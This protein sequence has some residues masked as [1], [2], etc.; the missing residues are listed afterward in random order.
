MT[1][2]GKEKESGVAELEDV[3]VD[4]FIRLCQF[5]YTG[6]FTVPKP[7]VDVTEQ[8]EEADKKLA[9]ALSKVVESDDEYLGF[10]P[11][12]SKTIKKGRK[13][14][15]VTGWGLEDETLEEQQQR[16]QQGAAQ[17]QQQKFSE[18]IF[19]TEFP[20][21]TLARSCE[22]QTN[23]SAS[24]N[25]TPVFVGYAS[26]Y[27]LADQYMIESL[28][29]LTLHKLHKTLVDFTLYAERVSDILELVQYTYSNSI[30]HDY[31]G[32]QLRSLITEYVVLKIEIIDKSE[33][34]AAVLEEGGP[35]VRDFW[36]LYRENHHLS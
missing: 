4:N 26:L 25:Y 22:P 6:D 33:Q 23:S 14:K 20:S 36:R 3:D 9:E 24:Q 32:D 13:G 1:G 18:Q 11:R 12:S 17:R 35:F 30:T 31:G 8:S 28:K 19:C 7:S 21:T 16:L 5:A 34:F 2:W 27:A 15:N 10:F 29:S